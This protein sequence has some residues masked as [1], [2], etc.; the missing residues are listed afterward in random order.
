MKYLFVIF[1]VFVL[2]SCKPSLDNENNINNGIEINNGNEDGNG[3]TKEIPLFFQ[4]TWYRSMN[5]AGSGFDTRLDKI[6]INENT[7]TSFGYDHY[8]SNPVDITYCTD[9]Y[10]VIFN[11]N[12]NDYE[13][14]FNVSW[15]NTFKF[16][17]DKSD[18][19]LL[20][21]ATIYGNDGLPNELSYY[22]IKNK[23]SK[24]FMPEWA[25]GRYSNS[26]YNYYTLLITEYPFYGIIYDIIFEEKYWQDIVTIN[27]FRGYRGSFYDYQN[28]DS[29]SFIQIDRIVLENNVEVDKTRIYFD[30]YYLERELYG[31]AIY[32]GSTDENN[33]FFNKVLI[34]K[35]T[36]L[37]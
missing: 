2:F 7:F 24:I 13:I 22:F 3:T 32:F 20:L 17:R 16:R 14:I 9:K 26:H 6:I 18:N 1:C 29:Y 30:N 11:E 36:Y 28:P 10:N 25:K 27:E 31:N 8:V 37:K 12:L 34:Q 4:G 33:K 35:I 23:P 15:N 19:V 5:T 21:T